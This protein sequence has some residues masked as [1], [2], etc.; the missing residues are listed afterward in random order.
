MKKI[1]LL[2]MVSVCT[3][4]TLLAAPFEAGGVW[5]EYETST[6]DLC[7]VCEA[8]YG[9]PKPSGDIIIPSQVTYK[10][11][12]STVV[13][14]TNYAFRDC[15]NL[16]SVQIPPSVIRI[17]NY[18]FQGSGIR[19]IT[20]P[21][22]VQLLQGQ[23]FVG[24][25]ELRRVVIE[26]NPYVYAIGEEM[27]LNCTALEEV[28][29]GQNIR[30][31]GDYC[32]KGSGIREFTVP[33]FVEK[34]GNRCFE[35]C[36]NLRKFT[37]EDERI[38]QTEGQYTWLTVG[39]YPFMRTN[40]EEVYIG[41]NINGYHGF[42]FGYGAIGGVYCEDALKRV[43]YAPNL[44]FVPTFETNYEIEEVTSLCTNPLP[45]ATSGG[46]LPFYDKVYKNATL[47]VPEEALGQYQSLSGWKEFKHIEAIKPTGIGEMKSEDRP[48]PLRGS[49]RDAVYDLQGRR[50]SFPLKGVR[51]SGI[52]VIN[53][54]KFYKK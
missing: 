22:T 49:T 42:M 47:Y 40:L 53:G 26:E 37:L 29:F 39:D 46:K 54:K 2:V 11:E 10:G 17:R 36:P 15:K 16:H 20:I 1:L 48:T 5:Y 28:V 33:N 4:A 51:G 30:S 43:T 52:Y 32:F 25:E 14:I 38:P 27:F 9:E 7:F 34:L 24:C 6:H 45:L 31:F 12:T 8:P 13:C 23:V 41:R 35:S 50:V 21:A 19:E 18:A 3:A 44:L